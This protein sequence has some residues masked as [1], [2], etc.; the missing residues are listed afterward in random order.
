[1]LGNERTIVARGERRTITV[2]DAYLRESIRHHEAVKV[3]GYEHATGPDFDER[4]LDD[5]R[6]DSLIVWM[7]SLAR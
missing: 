4:M 2:D 1:V 7:R 6:V 5:R 3:L